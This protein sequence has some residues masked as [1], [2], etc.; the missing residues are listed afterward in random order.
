MMMEEREM[1]THNINVAICAKLIE[2]E[3]QNQ[4][5]AFNLAECREFIAN[6]CKQWSDIKCREYAT[7]AYMDLCK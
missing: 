7:D 3:Q 6:N 5:R 1:T 4:R 2:I